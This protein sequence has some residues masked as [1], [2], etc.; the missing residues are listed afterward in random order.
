VQ[1]AT[2][3]PRLGQGHV[4]VAVR[5]RRVPGLRGYWQLLRQYLGPQRRAVLLMT[6]LLLTS[7][8][9]QLVGPQLARSF[10]DAVHVGMREETLIWLAVAFLLVSVVQAVMSVLATYWSE[11]V[12]WTATNALR[13]D[14]AA[15]LVRM[16]LSFHK[17]RTP[18]ELIERVDGD[19]SAL[20]GFFS[21]FVVQLVG[22]VLLLLGVLVAVYLVDTRLGGAFTAFA[23]L[24][25]VL[26]GWVRR[27]GTP[28]WKED[29]QHSAALY[30]YVG[31]VLT[32]TEDIRS[33][34][35][36]PYAMRRFFAHL[37]AWWPVRRR[38]GLW[39]QA[40]MMAAIA[41]FAVEEAIAY[42]LGGSLYQGR[43]LSLGAVYLVVAYTALLAAPIETIRTQL[44]NLQQADAAIA[45][46]RELLETKSRL[47]D[48]T[49]DLP[50][51]ALE[52]AFRAV[53][54]RYEDADGQNLEGS[55]RE[56]RVWV[57]QDLSFRLAAGRVLGLLGRTGSGKTT[58]ARLLFRLYDPQQGE[59]RVGG[60]NVRRARLAALRARVG[61]VTQDVQLFAASLRDNLTFFDPAIS[62]RQLH[63]VLETLGLKPWLERLPNG[64]ET[65]ISASSLSAGEAQLV[66]LARVFLKDPGLVILDEASSRLDLAAEALL[67]QTLHTLLEGRT[68]IIIAHRLATVERADDILEDGRLLEHGPRK[69]LAADPSSRFAE[70]RR[71]GRGDVLA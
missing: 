33:S 14:L 63:V 19:V 36:V 46:V 41:A 62:D 28:H 53:R 25:L 30:G 2:I 39:S 8:A 6:M 48:G 66:A 34:G 64:L 52:V 24:A 9:L 70:L 54:F 31:E 55:R 20:A 29:R 10:I 67:E 44:Q 12:A 17:A 11:R 42:G 22:S 38:A 71:T 4:T 35:A 60:V 26:L 59:V 27:L 3:T 56:E 23:V 13:A 16:D 1:Q 51:G 7:I 32:A 40:I 37:R 61:L 15:H 45:R 49:E 58:I 43:A 5:G 68:A 57:L 65:M 18:G 50:G 47:G 69:R 21:E